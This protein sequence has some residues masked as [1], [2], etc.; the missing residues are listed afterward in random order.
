MK[1]PKVLVHLEAAAAMAE[2]A[3]ALF[4]VEEVKGVELGQ[5]GAPAA[6]LALREGSIIGDL[7]T[8]HEPFGN[9]V[10]RP[11]AAESG[12][13]PLLF[14]SSQ[15]QN[16][17]R[18]FDAI[19]GARIR[20]IATGSRP[21]GLALRSAGPSGSGRPAILYVAELGD[22][23]VQAFEADTGIHVHSFGTGTAGAAADQLNHP[24]G[25]VLHGQAPGSDQPTL[26]FVADYNNHRV[27]VFD[28]DSTALLRTIGT[29]GQAGNAKGQFSNPRGLA[30][31]PPGPPGSGRTAILYVA[32]GN[33][34]RIQALEADTGSHLR[35]F[36]TGKKGAA[37]DQ[38]SNPLGVALH[39]PPLGSDQPTLLFVA[40]YGN[41]RV[42]VFDADTGALVRTIGQDGEA[43]GQLNHPTAVTVHPGADGEM[44]LFVT[45][46]GNNRVQAFVL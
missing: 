31:R 34:H 37:A 40:D 19:S 35:F 30:L 12:Q 13:P 29:T 8:L 7:D 38:L 25:L 39:E 32:E 44:I 10:V 27:Q 14:V 41:H 45:E 28:A 43:L 26:L 4:K 15:K 36:G 42:Q 5:T 17:V 24:Y 9:A 23:R 16:C 22:H 46:Y 11:A 18:V 1:G 6:P 2:Q 3:K 33:D 21:L 20:K